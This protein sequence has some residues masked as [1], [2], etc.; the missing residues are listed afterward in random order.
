MLLLLLLF[1]LVRLFLF[2]K[3]A[4]VA[5]SGSQWSSLVFKRGAF[6]LFLFVLSVS[7]INEP[8]LQCQNI[9]IFILALS[10]QGHRFAR[11]NW[12]VAH[13]GG[14]RSLVAPW[15]SKDAKM[16]IMKRKMRGCGDSVY[17]HP[18][19]LFDS[20]LG[21]YCCS[22][23]FSSNIV[24]RRGKFSQVCLFIYLFIYLFI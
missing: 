18:Q 10:K 6:F 3:T 19:L 17:D 23:R 24:G 1:V 14:H 7:G 13:G 21:L 2:T 11:Y 12:K 5:S 4:K 20:T 9:G 16:S 22:S 8:P 15:R